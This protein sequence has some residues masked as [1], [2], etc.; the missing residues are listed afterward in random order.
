MFWMQ[1]RRNDVMPLARTRIVETV[2]ATTMAELC[3]ARDA[4]TDAD[5]VELRID[6]VADIDVAAA[7]RG[8]RRQ[9][10]VIVTC[11][12][13]WEGG[14]FSGDEA[15]R[16]RLLGQ[17][18][19]AGADYVDVERRAGWVP[20]V[21]HATTRLI[22]SD[23]DF[24][25]IPED[26]GDR[27]REMRRLGADVV[28]VA[29]TAAHISDVLVLR[30]MAAAACAGGDLVCIA[31]GE[32][33]Q[34]TRL[35]PERFGSCWTYGGDAAPGQVAVRHL[36]DRYRV[37]ATTDHTRIFGVAGAPI[38]HSAS[39]AMHN[40]AYAAA[41]LDAIY[42]PVLAAT[43]DDAVAVADALGFEGLS[44][45]APLKTA[46]HTRA[47]VTCDDE[48][49]RRLGVVNTVRRASGRWTAK[50]LD[51]A[52]FLD[53]LDAR[54]VALVG[55]SVLVLGAG[56]AGRASAWAVAQR[57]A[58]V[59]LCA[60][61][62]DA[63]APVAAALGVRATAWPPSGSWDVVVNATPA[64]TWP[65][66]NDMPCAWDDLTAQVAYDLVYN[67]EETAWLQRARATGAQVIGGLDML[68]G[69]AARQFD[70]WMG[71]P[72]DTRVMRE[73]ARVF[74]GEMTG[75]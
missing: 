65:A 22:V 49:T 41:G 75:S 24:I 68:V 15:T 4:A 37:P 72:A 31:M 69:Q 33:G 45:T 74:V 19:D 63:A 44:I 73:A 8:R 62:R 21:D 5:L 71:R 13:E 42:V 29:V 23:H 25:S 60:R 66:V 55:A 2:T 56:G 40:A 10:P 20:N 14:R 59:V 26:L 47:D 16:R 32:A 9:V 61:R 43:V 28:K 67:P 51:T 30:R 35:L 50:N 38:A 27:V 1:G 64:G 36:R 53:A 46:W 57:G 18:V 52:G 3:A 34:L 58:N 54:G 12:P 17:A 11:R 48:A 39:P 7:V 6:G 70:W